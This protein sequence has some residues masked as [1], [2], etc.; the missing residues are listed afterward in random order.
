M[1]EHKNNDVSYVVK[2]VDKYIKLHMVAH[3]SVIGDDHVLILD[4][5]S[6]YF[7]SQ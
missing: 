5:I 2:K 3:C 6:L 7:H 4:Q 1:F